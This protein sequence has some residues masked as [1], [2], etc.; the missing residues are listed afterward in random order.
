MLWL[1]IEVRIVR[2]RYAQYHQEGFL[3]CR[4]LVSKEDVLELRHHAMDIYDGKVRFESVYA[5]HAPPQERAHMMHRVD[6]TMER[7]LLHR[8]VL[9]VVEALIGPDVLALQTMQFYNRPRTEAYGAKGGQ[10]WHQDSKYIATYPDTLIGTWLALDR[11]DEENGCLWVVPGSNNQPVFPEVKGNIA[12]VHAT[13]AFEI[14]EVANTSNLDDGVN[15]LSRVA[16]EYG[17]DTWLPVR[18][19]EGDVIYFHPHVLHRSHPNQST[20]RWRRAFVCHCTPC[21]CGPLRSLARDADECGGILF[22]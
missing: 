13:G 12:N 15:T 14:Q 16:H 11:A 5:S 17:E 7:Y 8:R 9:D 18:V 1:L 3:V 19:E 2:S 20:S 22:D 4:G 21:P 10:G 6:E